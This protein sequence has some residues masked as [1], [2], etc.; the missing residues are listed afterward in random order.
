MSY[1]R[2]EPNGAT[3]PRVRA[4][5]RL[6]GGF[7]TLAA[8]VLITGCN[9]APPETEPTPSGSPTAAASSTPTALTVAEAAPRYLAIVAPYNTALEKFQAAVKAGTSLAGLRVLAGKVADANAA[10]ARAL[11][12]TAWP[13]Q[14]RAPMAALLKETDAAEQCWRDAAQAKSATAMNKALKG[15]VEHD[16]GVP[17]GQVRSALG[18]PAYRKP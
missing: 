6:R 1:S 4:G 18:L 11:R 12:A 2:S 10:H 14:V 17:A 7:A 15:A 5:A 3:R 9:T 16:G 13:Q 8:V